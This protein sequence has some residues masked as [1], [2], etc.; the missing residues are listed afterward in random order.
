MKKIRRYNKKNPTDTIYID[1]DLSINGFTTAE[2]LNE[3][4]QLFDEELQKWVRDPNADTIIE[5]MAIHRQ[6][7]QIDTESQTTGTMRA[8]VL[9]IIDKLGMT[10][11][12]ADVKRVKEAEEKAVK[13]RKQLE[14]LQE[15]INN[16]KRD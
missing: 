5:A 8:C 9:A 7:N 1:E 14:E 10:V 13:L 16:V 4:Y 11:T 3:Q 6:L 15:K 2:P 12:D